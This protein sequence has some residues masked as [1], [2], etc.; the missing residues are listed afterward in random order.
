MPPETPEKESPPQRGLMGQTLRGLQVTTSMT[1]LRTVVDVGCQLILVRLLFPGAFGVL[2]FLHSTAGF[3]CYIADWGG[4]KYIIQKRDLKRTDVNTV[5]TIELL[6]GIFLALAWLPGA[7]I[8]LKVFHKQYLQPYVW[9]FTLWIVLERFQL[10]RAI[11]EKNM[12]FAK[13]NTAMFLGVLSGAVMSIVLA[14]RGCGVYSLIFGLLFRSLVS[15]LVLWFFTPMRPVPVIS[16]P[17]IRPYLKFGLPLMLTSL[18]TFYYWN[19]DYIIVGRVLNEEQL[20][21]YY[22]A[23]KFPHYM[24]TLQALVSTVVYPAFSR[25]RDDDQLKRGFSLSTKYSGAI[26]LLPCVAVLVLGGELV[27]YGLGEKWMPALRPLQVFTCLAAFRMITVHWYDVYLSR[28]KT[29]VMPFISASNVIGVSL[30]AY[31]G[32]RYFG[33]MGVAL[34]VAAVNIGVILVAVNFL[35]KR[36]LRVKYLAILSRPLVAAGACL[37]LS[38]LF[39]KL[40]QLTRPELD[41]A[42]KL[43]FLIVSYGLIYMALDHRSLREILKKA[44]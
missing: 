39:S 44:L 18:F 20:G 31:V 22:I 32:A 29:G 40:I 38:F 37:A 10:P 42:L 26:S 13:S 19:I 15:G 16:K 14:A 11:L 17:A 41:F 2:A 3:F 24:L 30:A 9:F 27:R 36:I 4:L 1:A 23:F 5:F 12:K 25:T 33:L 21:Y 6:A 28:G 7:H 43:A 8:I 34:G 35:L